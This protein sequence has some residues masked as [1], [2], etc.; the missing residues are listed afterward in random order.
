MTSQPS[1]SDFVSI[2]SSVLDIVWRER[3]SG[4]DSRCAGTEG[5]DSKSHSRR[6]LRICSSL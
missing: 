3:T 1:E 6:H 4:S 2:C 5:E